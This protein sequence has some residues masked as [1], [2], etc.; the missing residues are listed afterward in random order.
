LHTRGI[1]FDNL[2]IVDRHAEAVGRNRREGRFVALAVGMASDQERHLAVA[3]HAR[4][5]GLVAA[6]DPA[7]LWEGA[8]GAGSGLVQKGRHANPEI[9]T[10]LVEL[11]LLATELLIAR[12][13]RE[14]VESAGGL[15]PQR[16]C[17]IA[18]SGALT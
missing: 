7:A 16:R 10:L 8:A 12:Q 14:L 4:G 2:N 18:P 13:R 1:A 6:R 15:S 9:D 17:S 5:C 11:R 3:V